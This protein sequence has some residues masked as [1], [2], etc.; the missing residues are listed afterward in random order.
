MDDSI[1]DL[2]HSWSAEPGPRAAAL[3]AILAHEGPGGEGALNEAGIRRRTMSKVARRL[4]P[5]MIA[6]FCAN[7]LD[8]VNIGFAAGI[9]FVSYTAPEIP[10]NLILDRV[11]ASVWLARIMIT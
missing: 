10:S 8:R 4:I 1:Q 2:R 11:G 5:F 3:P 6:M 7:F 9:L